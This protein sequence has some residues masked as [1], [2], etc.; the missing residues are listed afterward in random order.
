[1][2]VKSDRDHRLRRIQF[3]RHVDDGR[4]RLGIAAWMVMD[5]DHCLGVMPQGGINHLA[6]TIRRPVDRVA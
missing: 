4:R 5:E 2:I 6:H 1:M 3:D